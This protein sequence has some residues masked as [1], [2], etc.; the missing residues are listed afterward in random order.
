MNLTEYANYDGLQLADLIRRKLVSA[1]EVRNV[2]FEACEKVNGSIN[3][4]IELWDDERVAASADPEAPFFG[5]PF[6]VK[7][8]GVSVAGRLNEL[9]SRLAKDLRPSADSTLMTQFRDAGFVTIGRTTTPEF[10]I[11]I[12]T[13]A[14]F[15]GVTR[16]PWD[17]SHSPGGSSGGSGAAVAA[18][19]VPVAHATDGGGSIRIPASANGV[20]G[21][22]PTRGRVSNG[23]GV[24][25]IWSGLVVQLGVSRSVRDSAALLDVAQGGANGEPYYTRG[26]AA[27]FRSHTERDPKPLKIGMM[28]EPPNGS[29]CCRAVATAMSQTAKLCEDLGHR[30]EPVRFESGVSWEAFVLANARVW[31]CN[32]TAWVDA[33]ASQT[34]RKPNDDALEPVTRNAYAYGQNVSATEFLSALNM[35]NIVS[36]SLATYFE[37]YD[38]LLTPTL[39][40]LPPALGWLYENAS[41]LDGLG[42][43]T[44]VF[45]SSPFTALAN[46]AGVPAMSVPLNVDNVSGLPI[47]SQ[48]F[49]PFGDDGTLLSLAAQLERAAPWSDRRPLV[50]VAAS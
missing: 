17:L 46:M 43:V 44:R 34:G 49:A 8:L 4:V 50:S 39:P 26:P 42:W 35:R 32:T 2:A 19:I 18:G 1:E 5:V 40:G 11:S 28:I 33:V 3:A 29:R 47:G 31:T 45:N 24:D 27:T 30:I 25:E 16:N 48:F 7:D 15:P 14:A 9:G 21:L 10:G 6:L 36:R 37:Q 13:E 20:F 38:I 41:S 23:P 22:K 12:T